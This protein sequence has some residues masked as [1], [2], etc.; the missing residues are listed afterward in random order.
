MAKIYSLS[1]WQ[2]FINC[3]LC[4]QNYDS[5]KIKVVERKDGLM[6]FYLV[7]PRCK[8]SV[9]TMVSASS[10]GVTSV[11]MLTDIT[12]EDMERFKNKEPI[13]ADD[14]LELH[15]FLEGSN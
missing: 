10:L 12:E 5:K 8:S 7:C 2:N 1:D 3:P 15:M 4:G 11:S 9:M 6:I 14:V 13:S